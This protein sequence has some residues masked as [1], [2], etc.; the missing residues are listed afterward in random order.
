MKKIAAL[1]FVFVFLVVNYAIGE[2]YEDNPFAP[3]PALLARVKAEMPQRIFDNAHVYDPAEAQFSYD[4]DLI[5]IE[6]LCRQE[7]F[8]FAILTIDDFIGTGIHKA[9]AEAFYTQMD[10]GI[11]ENR[12]GALF[13][14]D[15]NQ[16]LQHLYLAGDCLQWVTQEEADKYMYERSCNF[17]ERFSYL[18][19]TTCMTYIRD[20]REAYMQQQ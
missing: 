9:F 19:P 18:A 5:W 7:G 10:L 13:I 3:D 4:Y 16:K 14:M 8:D 11:G 6:M 1:L 17:D 12:S 2:S 15:F 20:A